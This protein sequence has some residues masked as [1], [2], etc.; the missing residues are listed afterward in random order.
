M[1]CAFDEIIENDP[2]SSITYFSFRRDVIAGNIPS[3]KNGRRY[4]IDM[5]DVEKYYSHNH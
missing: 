4:Y 2:R 3:I 1:R 5:R